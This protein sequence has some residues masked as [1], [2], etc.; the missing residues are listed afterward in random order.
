VVE[1]QATAG[2]MG[3]Q[4]VTEA[5]RVVTGGRGLGRPESFALLEELATL[6][7]GSV[8]ATRSVVDAGWRP[9]DEQV[10]KSGATIAPELYLAFGVSGAIH[11]VLGMN[12]AQVV[13]AVNTDPEAPIFKHADHG[14]VG[15]AEQ[16]LETLLESLR[17][18]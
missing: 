3:K 7:D 9:H 17:G 5:S 18:S 4:N 10:G 6:L 2:K 16:V 11:H 8:G 15:D 13:V 12:T 1:Q 14:I